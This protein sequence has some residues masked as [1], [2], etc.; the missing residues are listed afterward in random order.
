VATKKGDGVRG[1]L[2][3]LVSKDKERKERISQSEEIAGSIQSPEHEAEPEQAA[4][5]VDRGGPPDTHGLHRKA[6]GI[7]GRPRVRREDITVPRG[8]KTK[9][10]LSIDEVLRDQFYRMAHGEMMQPGEFVERALRYYIKHH[11]KRD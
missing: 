1:V 11:T 7:K 10:T 6:S 3:D 5:E 2:G 8:E 9:V 4:R